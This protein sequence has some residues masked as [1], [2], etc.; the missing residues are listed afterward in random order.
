MTSTPLIWLEEQGLAVPRTKKLT[1]AEEAQLLAA[2]IETEKHALLVELEN[3]FAKGKIDYEY[4]VTKFE[5][6]HNVFVD[7]HIEGAIQYPKI[8]I[9]I[10]PI[11]IA[12]LQVAKHLNTDAVISLGELQKIVDEASRDLPFTVNFAREEVYEEGF[13]Y[14]V[15]RSEARE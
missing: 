7:I 8:T 9:K 2:K 10:T 4:V 3:Q 14:R 6:T 13:R 12:L 5:K 1:E 15:T 11:P